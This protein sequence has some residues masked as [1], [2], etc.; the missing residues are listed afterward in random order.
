RW[1]ELYGSGFTQAMNFLTASQRQRDKELQEKE[2]FRQ[3][4]LL[5]VQALAA[6]REKRIEQQAQAAHSLGRWLVAVASVAT[7]AL[8]VTGLAIWESRVAHQ[9]TRLAKV[10]ESKALL[11][12]HHAE[13]ES[14]IAEEQKGKAEAQTL[15][16]E[17]QKREAE[18]A[19][20]GMRLQALRVR[21]AN[22]ESMSNY[23]DMAA[24]LAQVSSPQEAA[25][26]NGEQ[27][28]ALLELGDY[29]DAERL[30]TDALNVVPDDLKTRTSRGY[31][32]LLTKQP[33]NALQDFQ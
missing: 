10:A 16:A 3:R 6:E 8:V 27:G 13:E 19:N 30:L 1:A 2:E 20:R 28:L 14:R 29:G 24:N 33:A 23:A 11:A 17:R 12:E 32:Y 9:K 22:L 4:E 5:Q 31:L 18:S 15:E 26:W 21:D 7:L 25:M